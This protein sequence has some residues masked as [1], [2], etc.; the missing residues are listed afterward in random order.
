MGDLNLKELYAE[1]RKKAFFF[2]VIGGLFLVIVS[3][4]YLILSTSH[5]FGYIFSS[6]PDLGSIALSEL[7]EDDWYTYDI[8]KLYGYYSYNNDGAIYITSYNNEDFVSI[9]V[10]KD[11]KNTAEQITQDTL[12]YLKG[13]RDVPSDKHLKGKGYLVK[14][15]ASQKSYLEQYLGI[16]IT[17]DDTP[18]IEVSDY[19]LMTTTPFKLIFSRLSVSD[20][21]FL[22]FAV[23]FFFF[24]IYGIFSFIFGAHKKKFKKAMEKYGILE[25]VLEKDMENACVI[26]NAYIGNEHVVIYDSVNIKIVPFDSL[27]WAYMHVTETQHTTYGVKTKST[28]SYQV[29]MWDYNKNKIMANVKNESDAI[30]IIA[31]MHNKAPYFYSGYSKELASATDGGRF[32]E[33]VSAVRESRNRYLNGGN[34]NDQT[35]SENQIC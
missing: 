23:F 24:G 4:F 34:I 17:S 8:N 9:F 33:M 1:S 18:K 30:M 27:I 29:I 5:L 16:G 12:D 15:D 25:E 28:K 31:E 21:M 6:K 13:T 14:L 3:F 11:D 22:L 32:D 19:Y 20:L 10:D 26:G 7:S 35:I 2:R